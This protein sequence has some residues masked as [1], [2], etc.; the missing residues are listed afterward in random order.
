MNGKNV[1]VGVGV[2]VFKNG[3][4]IMLKRRG[5]HGADTWSLPGGHLEFG[6][7]LKIPREGR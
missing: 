4:F 3:E 7:H 6:N 2:F 5:S 1:R